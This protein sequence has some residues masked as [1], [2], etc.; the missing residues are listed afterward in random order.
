WYQE[1]PNAA[2]TG[3]AGASSAVARTGAS[4]AEG[5]GAG[6]HPAT[7]RTAHR[8]AHRRVFIAS[9]ILSMSNEQLLHVRRAR[10]RVVAVGRNLVETQRTVERLRGPHRREGVE[11]HALVAARSRRVEDGFGQP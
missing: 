5:V 9:E 6:S 10:I 3:P 8:R 7:S 4:G 2:A 1:S 11:P